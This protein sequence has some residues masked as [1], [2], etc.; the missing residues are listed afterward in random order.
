MSTM[1]NMSDP[2]KI[3]LRS[4]RASLSEMTLLEPTEEL[5]NGLMPEP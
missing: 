5:L 3:R 4:P 2:Q 1:M